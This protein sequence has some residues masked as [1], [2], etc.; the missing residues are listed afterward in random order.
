MSALTPRE[1]YRLWA[2]GYEAENA[3]TALEQD[4]V[5][6][7]GPSPAGLSL[8]DAGCGT[9][10]RL[11]GTGAARAVGVDLSPEMLAQGRKNQALAGVE[12][13]EGDIGSL[14]VPNAEFELVW[15]RLVIGHVVELDR[16]FAELARVTRA[17][18]TVVVTDFHPAAHA[19]GHRR[20]FR[21]RGEVFEAEHHARSAEEL[22]A[23]AERAGMVLRDRREAAIGP[24]VR[25]YYQRAGRAALYREHRG[26]PVV[27]A[28]AFAR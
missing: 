6:R 21:H 14:P 13:L 17:G 28:L 11:A 18:S 20:T 9:G 4:L 8:L 23:A 24:G 15:C 27:L 2:P 10:R 25:D 3:V 5:A 1:A 26:L 22:I 16:A 19:A 7:L 12:L